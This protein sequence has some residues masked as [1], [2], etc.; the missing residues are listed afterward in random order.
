MLK[1]SVSTLSGQ[2]KCNQR[3][4]DALPATSFR[5]QWGHQRR[6]FE[7]SDDDQIASST[8]PGSIR[9]YRKT[10]FVSTSKVLAMDIP[11]SERV[12]QDAALYQGDLT[13]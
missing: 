6:R 9:A 10:P 3:C 4:C 7:N 11:R 8:G 1:T 13:K 2:R 12:M 5:K